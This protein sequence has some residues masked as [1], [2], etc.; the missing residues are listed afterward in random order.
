MFWSFRDDFGS[1]CSRLKLVSLSVVELFMMMNESLSLSSI[2][3]V[4]VDKGRGGQW[5]NE[6][7]SDAEC[8]RPKK[9]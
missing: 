1:Y 8:R 2:Y 9:K 3:G 4:S 7:D 6:S 5:N